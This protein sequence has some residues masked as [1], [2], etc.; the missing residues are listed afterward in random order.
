MGLILA[1]GVALL[2]SFKD[3]AMKM[4]N[5]RIPAATFLAT[6]KLLVFLILLPIAVVLHHTPRLSANLLFLLIGHTTL[7]TVAFYL[8][9]LAVRTSPLSLSV[10]LLSLSPVFLL[11]TSRL[12]LNQDIPPIGAL[13]VI[14]VALGSY[15]LGSDTTKGGLLAPIR[16]LLKVKGGRYMLVVALIWSITANLDRIGVDKVGALWWV[17]MVSL[18][19]GIGA[20]LLGLALERVGKGMRSIGLVML[21]GIADSIS[22]LFQ[23]WAITFAPVPY[24]IS[25]KRTSVLI[26]TLLGFWIFREGWRPKRLLGSILMVLG[27][28]LILSSAL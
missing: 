6:Y 5:R 12:M 21:V 19:V 13:G 28:A 23:M 24:V 17:V 3:V 9:L 25:I 18:G 4:S 16:S 1:F 15:V 20:W 8:Y 14:L 7:N 27:S 10:P 11:L 22:S 26:S 2:E